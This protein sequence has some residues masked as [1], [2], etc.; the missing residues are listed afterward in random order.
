[1]SFFDDGNV[2][3]N[4][5]CDI[6]I[7]YVHF[8]LVLLANPT[9][10]HFEHFIVYCYFLFAFHPCKFCKVTPITFVMVILQKS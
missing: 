8:K 9:C 7:F 2:S 5:N 3:V 6:L 10:N 1:M 4:E